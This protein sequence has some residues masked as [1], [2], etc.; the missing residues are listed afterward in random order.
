MEL[1]RYD[2]IVSWRAG[3]WIP[4]ADAL[5]RILKVGR[6]IS[7]TTKPVMLSE[8]H[9]LNSESCDRISL[10]CGEIPYTR[11]DQIAAM[12]EGDDAERN[13]LADTSDTEAA[14][15][16]VVAHPDLWHAAKAAILEDLK[17]YDHKLEGNDDEI[18]MEHIKQ[19][20]EFIEFATRCR[21][22][23]KEACTSTE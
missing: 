17:T 9:V 20:N 10:V 14:M 4:H 8:P 5:S 12:L 3:K 21:A 7:L 22:K 16:N 1:S 18:Y 6:I 11:E 19:A 15:Q 13:W 2:V 23:G